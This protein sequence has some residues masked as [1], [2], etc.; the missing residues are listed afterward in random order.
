[1]NIKKGDFVK[2]ICRPSKDHIL[3]KDGIYRVVD[4]KECFYMRFAECTDFCNTNYFVVKV[5]IGNDWS[6]ERIRTTCRCKI[7]LHKGSENKDCSCYSC[8][9]R[10]MCTIEL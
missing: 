7:E 6:F 10:L 1:M 4:I 5:C 3:C 8:K 9:D 2:V